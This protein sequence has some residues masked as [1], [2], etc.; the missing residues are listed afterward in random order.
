MQVISARGMFYF[1]ESRMARLNE[2]S[3]PNFPIIVC[4]IIRVSDLRT[5]FACRMVTHRVQNVAYFAFVAAKKRP[6]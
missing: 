5:L 4:A 2:N 3:N 1:W 6:Q